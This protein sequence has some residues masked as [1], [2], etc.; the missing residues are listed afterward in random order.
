[1][2]IG[3]ENV[4]RRRKLGSEEKIWISKKKVTLEE[5]S[6]IKKEKI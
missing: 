4:V 3:R 2:L 5:K 1:M 6:L